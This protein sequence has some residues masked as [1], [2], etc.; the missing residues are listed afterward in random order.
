[1]IVTS[2]TGA[3]FAREMT[4]LTCCGT[5]SSWFRGFGLNPAIDDCDL[6]RSEA[7]SRVSG[8]RSRA[9]ADKTDWILALLTK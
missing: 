5:A 7:L 4:P 8:R 3:S 9:S 1:L 2:S 6:H